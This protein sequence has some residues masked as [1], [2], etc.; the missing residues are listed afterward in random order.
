MTVLEC[1]GILLPSSIAVVG[2]ASAVESEE[3]VRLDID[4]DVTIAVV[5]GVAIFVE[6]STVCFGSG[7]VALGAIGVERHEVERGISEG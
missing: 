4:S 7:V 3:V 6:P 5:V 2:V 1:D